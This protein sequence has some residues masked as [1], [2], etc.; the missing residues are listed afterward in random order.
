MPRQYIRDPA[1]PLKWIPVG[2]GSGPSVI[3]EHQAVVIRQPD[4]SYVLQTSFA[5]L[6]YAFSIQRPISLFVEIQSDVF[7]RF[8]LATHGINDNGE[9]F[10]FA[11]VILEDQIATGTT[12]II[13]NERGI[14]SVSEVR[15]ELNNPG[16]D[17]EITQD[18]VIS[19]LGYTP[20]SEEILSEF[21]KQVVL[22]APQ[23]ELTGEQK[24]IARKNIGAIGL[25]SVIV[26]VANDGVLEAYTVSEDNGTLVGPMTG[27][28][29]KIAVSPS[30]G[31]Y[32]VF[33]PNGDGL[34]EA[35]LIGEWDEEEKTCVFFHANRAPDGQSIL[36]KI[37]LEETTGTYKDVPNANAE[38][39][40][41]T[42][43]ELPEVTEDAP[44]LV[45]LMDDPIDEQE[46]DANVD[47]TLSIEGMAADAAAVGATLSKIS[48]QKVDV[49]QGVE[50]AGKLLGI[51]TGGIV[52]P[53]DAPSSGVGTDPNA[54][55]VVDELPPANDDAP[56]VVYLVDDETDTDKPDSQN[57]VVTV[58]EL[59][60]ATEESPDLVYLLND[61]TGGES[62]G[63]TEET[64][65]TV[66]GWAKQPEKPDYTASEVGAI[67][68]PATAEV[69]QVMRVAAVD[70]SGKPSAWDK[71]N[72]AGYGL[73]VVG[74]KLK[75]KKAD[76][77]IRLIGELTNDEQVNSFTLSTDMA[78]NSISITEAYI[79][80]TLKGEGS[81]TPPVML[82]LVNSKAAAYI[83]A[84]LW[85]GGGKSYTIRLEVINRRMFARNQDCSN[86]G[87][88]Q[89]VG[90][91]QHY[92]YGIACGKAEIESIKSV[93]VM[94]LSGALLQT[95]TKLELYEMGVFD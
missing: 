31:R 12:I 45:F 47:P 15:A 29:I 88:G 22:Y 16:V 10:V 58:E 37:P 94:C 91:S 61:E 93:G 13:K 63:I 51:G 71:V 84:D 33:V 50:N 20:L 59:P 72:L 36:V 80:L 86:S 25:N 49:D 60:E 18:E 26:F 54:V 38:N 14:V 64:D 32:Q 81:S 66:P 57:A 43:D 76:Q 30:G 2:G 53:V 92:L 17:S 41:I 21:A 40:V 28:E 19:A 48:T 70:A 3:T 8:D 56:D 69:G 62:G 6:S 52:V 34:T 89:Y 23:N 77:P 44:D 67:P 39:V 95:G 1:N 79:V 73:E 27:E 85:S 9:Y 87:G 82:L 35:K 4:A 55:Q 83:P 68:A 42:V 74:G 78:G 11:Q 75:S 46:G 24:A 7:Q 5:E 65:P 90:K